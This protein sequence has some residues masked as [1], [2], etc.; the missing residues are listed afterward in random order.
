MALDA[1]KNPK[2]YINLA[3]GMGKKTL[4]AAGLRNHWLSCNQ[5]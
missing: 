3:K 2:T 5:A 4:T 1:I